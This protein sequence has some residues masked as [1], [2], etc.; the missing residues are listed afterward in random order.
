MGLE[1]NIR[2]TMTK[3]VSELLIRIAHGMGLLQSDGTHH[4]IK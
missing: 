1:K 3:T 4:L 2:V